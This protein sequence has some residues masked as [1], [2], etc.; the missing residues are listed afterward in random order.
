MKIKKTELIYLQSQVNPHFLFNTLNNI[1]SLVH[2]KSDKALPA[3]DKLTAILRYSLYEKEEKISIEKE[4]ENIRNFIQ[5]EEMRYSYPLNIDFKVTGNIVNFRL[6]PFLLL[7]LVENA[8]K[9]G[10]MKSPLIIHLEIDDET[11]AFKVK[12]SIRI[13]QKDRLGGIGL[14]N[15]EKRLNL[16]YGELHHL[17]IIQDELSFEVRLVINN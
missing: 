6:P 13:K 17:N 9:H 16:I 1:Y 12:N 14:E 7:P 3:L 5:L 11:L 10:D 4:L 15:I 2:R 8:F